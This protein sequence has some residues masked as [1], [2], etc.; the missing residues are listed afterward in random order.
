GLPGL[1]EAGNPAEDSSATE[2]GGRSTD[3]RRH[4]HA[5]S[6]SLRSGA[7]SCANLTADAAGRSH[8]DT[9]RARDAAGA[10]VSSAG[11]AAGDSVAEGHLQ[12]D[13]LPAADSGLEGGQRGA[14]S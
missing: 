3:Y 13:H 10:A 12:P 5:L 11:I 14:S 7:V 9:G 4:R 8:L 6:W 2:L 1:D